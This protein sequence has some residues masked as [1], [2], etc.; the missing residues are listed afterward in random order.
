MLTEPRTAM[1][2]F[3]VWVNTIM[4]KFT[5][6]KGIE[7]DVVLVAHNGMCQDHVMLLKTMMVCG[8][9][10]PRWRLAD[11]L[12]IFKVVLRPNDPCSLAS[13]AFMY[14][15]WFEHI[16]HDSLS[17][18]EALKNVVTLADDGWMV[19]CLTF[20][21]STEFFITSIGLNTFGV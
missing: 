21:C 18:A 10:P 13:L 16:A 20:S 11:S 4:N 17:D 6:G 14:A 12:P 15:P 3:I 2:H 9:V 5:S 7:E 1:K 19:A 8:I